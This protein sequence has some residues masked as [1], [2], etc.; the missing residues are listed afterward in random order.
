M[1][2]NKSMSKSA[3]EIQKERIKAI[4]ERAAHLLEECDLI[5]IASINENGYPRICTVSK[6]KAYGF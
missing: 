2:E 4:E 5:T 1:M 3:N 6:L